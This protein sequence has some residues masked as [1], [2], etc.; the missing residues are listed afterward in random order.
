[1]S[2]RNKSTGV[3]WFLIIMYGLYGVGVAIVSAAIPA[4]FLAGLL[5]LSMVGMLVAMAVIL[6]FQ[7]V[8]ISPKDYPILAHQPV[9]S[10]TYFA[11]KLTTVLLYVG[12]IG[13]LTGGPATLAYLLKFGPLVAAACVAALAGAIVWITLAMIFIYAAMLHLFRPDRLRRVLSYVQ[14]VFTTGVFATPFIFFE[15][16]DTMDWLGDIDIDQW[17]AAI[18]LPP[19]WFASLLPLAAGS[20][21][22]TGVLAVLMAALT[23]AALIRYGGGRLSLSYAERLGALVAASEAKRRRRTRPRGPGKG[24]FSPEL[25]VILALVRAQFRH[26]MKF[27]M[28]VLGI[29]PLTVFYVFIALSEGPLPD[30]FVEIGVGAVGFGADGLGPIHFAVLFMPPMLLMELFPQ[31][32]VPCVVGLL[33]RASG[34]DQTHHSNGPV[35]DRLLRHPLSRCG[36]GHLRMGLRE[37]LTRPG[38]RVLPRTPF[39]HRDAIVAAEDAAAA[40]LPAAKLGSDEP[41]VFRGVLF[42]RLDRR[43]GVP[44][45]RSLGGVRGTGSNNRGHGTSGRRLRCPAGRGGAA[46]SA[47]SP[48]TGIR[49]LKGIARQPLSFDPEWKKSRV[50]P[51]ASQVRWVPQNGA[52]FPYGSSL[53]S[54]A[55]SPRASSASARDLNPMSIHSGQSS[56]RWLAEQPPSLGLYTV[57]SPVMTIPIPP[58]DRPS[59]RGQ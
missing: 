57:P 47:P 31:R 34:T 6:D 12:G 17:P 16:A 20:W 38:P 35:R 58:P 28:V 8:V 25:R 40:V 41:W 29:L 36:G 15:L 44:S 2:S 14:V 32:F 24:W 26:D 1:M 43:D 18:L 30:P 42:S 50:V 13:A 10:R 49:R 23:T 39:P 51:C 19:G 37:R 27:R 22:V 33:H 55:S 46:H 54:A 7:S 56:E 11:A 48:R 53:P 52:S 45:T 5:T 21:S 4:L 9:S 3:P 59:C